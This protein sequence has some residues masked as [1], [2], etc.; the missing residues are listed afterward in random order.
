MNALLATIDLPGARVESDRFSE[1]ARY[2]L[3][4]AKVKRQSSAATDTAGAVARAMD[5]RTS[6]GLK[7]H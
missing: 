2:I 4:I 1:T 6:L 5:R 7:R 3:H